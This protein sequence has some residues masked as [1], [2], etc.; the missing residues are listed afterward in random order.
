MK[1]SII[2]F[3]FSGLLV[4]GCKKYLDVNQNVNQPTVVTP[5]VVLSSALNGTATNVAQDFLNLPRW[6][7]YWSRSGNYVPDVQTE[8]Y[9]IPNNYTDLELSLIHI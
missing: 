8:T 4:G 7:A 6:M 3:L 2:L 5:S 9:A 1:K